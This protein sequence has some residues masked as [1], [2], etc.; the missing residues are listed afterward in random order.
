MQAHILVADNQLNQE[1][2]LPGLLNAKRKCSNNKNTKFRKN[3]L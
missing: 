2:Y 3:N 1:K